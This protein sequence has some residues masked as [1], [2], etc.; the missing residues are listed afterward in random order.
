[1][2]RGIY[3]GP[4][5][6]RRRGQLPLLHQ[7]LR[8]RRRPRRLQF[9]ELPA[10]PGDGLR[11]GCLLRREPPL[12]RQGGNAARSQP[13]IQTEIVMRI[14]ALAILAIAMVAAAAP[15]SAQ[16]YDP[17]Y[18]VCLRVYGLASYNE[19]RYFSMAQCAMSASGRAAQCVLNPYFAN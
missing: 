17:G 4:R 18:P 13:P 6:R 14:L 9:L 1:M 8:F 11:P 3:R 16:T 10:V 5:A 2:L 19:C 15:G 7:G 12:Q